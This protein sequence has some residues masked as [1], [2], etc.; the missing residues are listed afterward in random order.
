MSI[1][2]KNLL[3]SG[4]LAVWGAVSLSFVASGR[5][6][7]YLHPAFHP[8]TV[9]SGLILV[10]LAASV[11]FFPAE[12]EDC[13]DENCGASHGPRSMA[14]LL[15]VCSILIV[16]LLAATA[17]SP[18]QFGAVAVMNRGLAES[19]EDLPGAS[20]PL[21]EPALPTLD[22]SPGEETAVGDIAE[23]MAK[24]DSGQIIAS[25]IDLLYAAQEPG[26][27]RDFENR[28][29]ELVGQFFPAK[30]N[31][32]SGDRFSL[33]RMFV[34]CCAADARPVAITVRT[35]SAESFPDMS[36]I[37]V[38]GKA[39]FP[40]EG[41]RHVPVIEAATVSSTDAP[42]ESFVY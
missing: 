31:N 14:G 16:P 35:S 36:W 7:S 8:W 37:K 11:I 9:A 28:E 2:F 38:I 34:L 41:G 17:I 5:V 24:N 42:Q 29:V 25:T 21:T 12:E 3:R 18:S 19:I 20:A 40:M 30:K 22:G 33:V 4:T 13:P 26:M 27:R 15:G 6:S 39:T 32:P 10:F 23:Y 1:S